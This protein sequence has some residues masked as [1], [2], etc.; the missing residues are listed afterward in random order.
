MKIYGNEKTI[1]KTVACTETLDATAV[2]NGETGTIEYSFIGTLKEAREAAPALGTKTE[3]LDKGRQNKLILFRK[4]FI[5]NA[6]SVSVILTYNEPETE[7]I[8]IGINDNSKNTYNLTTS[9]KVAPIVKNPKYKHLKNTAKGQ[10]CIAVANGI[11]SGLNPWDRVFLKINDE[12]NWVVSTKENGDFFKDLIASA[13]KTNKEL[14]DA[15][16]KGE[17]SYEYAALK[18]TVTTKSTGA[19]SQSGMI[20]KKATPPG[21]PPKAPAG[22]HWK[23]TSVASNKTSSDLWTHTTTYETI[24]DDD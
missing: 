17:T 8:D 14:I 3:L 6:D 7:N 4:N 24:E 23:C 21:N 2:Q 13:K 15:C 19:H 5:E 22:T 10:A 12:G 16:L 11:I 1:V 9:P 18:W 20:N